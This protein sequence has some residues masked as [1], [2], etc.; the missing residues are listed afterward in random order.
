MSLVIPKWRA[1]N[2]AR[3]EELL[4]Q[5]PNGD[6]DLSPATVAI[7]NYMPIIGITELSEENAID[8]LCR[9]TLVECLFGPVTATR[10]DSGRP[11]LYF[12]TKDDVFRHVGL[13]TEG[14]AQSHAEFFQFLLRRA[15]SANIDMAATSAYIANGRMTLLQAVEEM[16]MLLPRL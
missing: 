1:T 11:H 14:E 9:I 4:V 3:W 12:V 6:F 5:T 2:V 8:A 15:T 13:E 7:L 10:D 16:H